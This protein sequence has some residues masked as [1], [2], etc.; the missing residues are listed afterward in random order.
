MLRMDGTN[1]NGLKV[2]HGITFFTELEGF[3]IPVILYESLVS[4]KKGFF[5]IAPYSNFVSH[6]LNAEQRNVWEYKLLL[7]HS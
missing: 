6:Y 7:L 2:S 4:G 1:D 3:N 5:Q